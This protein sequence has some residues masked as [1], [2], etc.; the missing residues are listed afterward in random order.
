M[1][2]V[3]LISPSDSKAK[4]MARL[5]W[6]SIAKPLHSLGLLEEA[7]MKIAGISGSENVRIDKRCAVI[8]CADNGVIA[9]GVTQTDSSV[10]ML[11]AESIAAGSANISRMAQAFNADVFPVDIGMNTDSD[12]SKIIN[13]KPSCGTKNISKEAA[14]TSEQAKAAISAGIDMVK[15]CNENGYEIIVTGEMGIGNTTTSSTVAALLLGESA[16][17][18]TGKGAGLDS[19][20]LLRKIAAV[21]KAILVNRPN[22]NDAVDIISKI[23]G[24]D[25]AGI[26][27]LF[28]GGA[29]YR[30]P[31]VIDGFISA[32]AAALAIK[33]NPMSKEFMLC[34]HV[35]K[36]P[37]CQNS[38]ADRRQTFD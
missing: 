9:E 10:T 24:Y 16:A 13:L 19:N 12:N 17:S 37:A 31:V 35:S 26:T 7:V 38:Q 20:G 30:V 6:N 2:R 25:I 18:V 8:M 3:K 33:I 22:I 5:H 11:V 21:E 34:S 4:S 15:K 28:L 36:E 27:G 1:D 14:M 23:G 32:V 29:I